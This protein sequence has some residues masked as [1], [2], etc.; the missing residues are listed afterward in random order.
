MIPEETAAAI[1]FLRAAAS[2]AQNGKI[3]IT[4][5]EQKIDPLTQLT[6]GVVLEYEPDLSGKSE[7]VK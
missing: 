6:I 5:F 3:V 7:D 1:D 4:K 2:D